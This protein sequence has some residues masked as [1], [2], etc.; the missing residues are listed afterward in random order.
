MA[1]VTP[2]RRTPSIVAMNSCVSSQPVAGDGLAHLL[3]E[4]L[5]VVLA[6]SAHDRQLLE[7]AAEGIGLH[8]PGVP[9]HLHRHAL[10]HP[11]VAEQQRESHEPLVPDRADL[12]RAALLGDGDDRHGAVTD[13]VHVTQRHP[14]LRQHLFEVEARGTQ[15]RE[16]AIVCRERKAPQQS[17]GLCLVCGDQPLA[18]DAV[19]ET[20][21]VC[22]QP[23]MPRIPVAHQDRCDRPA[24]RRAMQRAGALV[25]PA[26]AS[27]DSENVNGRARSG[28]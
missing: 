3:E 24:G 17:V 26:A 21:D 7:H 10:R 15:L 9:L 19:W 13:E 6:A 1:T 11:V 28:R 14:R 16:Q 2:A 20:V 4:V 18:C 8:P 27:S 12:D 5:R 23:G 25:A 22:A